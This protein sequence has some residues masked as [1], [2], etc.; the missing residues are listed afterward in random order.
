MKAK[1]LIRKVKGKG[2][3]RGA[4]IEAEKGKTF[5]CVACNRY[6]TIPPGQVGFCGVRANDNGKFN[7][8]VY[9]KPCAVWIDPIEKKPMFHFLPGSKSYSLGTFGCNFACSFCFTPDSTMVN[10]DFINDLDEVFDSCSKK[11]QKENGEI[12]FAGDRKTITASGNKET[13]SKVFRHHYSGPMLTIQPRHAPSL[14]CTPEHRF[15]VYKNGSIEKVP[16][17]ELKKNDLLI[18]PKINPKNEKV[19]LDCKAILEK[20]ISRIKKMRKLDQ[21]G[22]ERL[23]TLKKAGKTS[24]EI[25]TILKMHP[26]YIRHLNGKLKKEG[27]HD[28]TFTYDNLVFEKFDRVKFKM[29]KGDGVPR[30]IDVKEEFAEL[31]G[32]YCAEG[33]T[34]HCGQRPSSFNVVFSYGKHEKKLVDRTI[35]LL[36]KLFSVNPKTVRRRTTITVE[37]SKSSLGTLFKFLCG[38]K[39]KHKKVPSEIARSNEK[40]ISAFMK[41]FL[42]GDGCV[43]KEN[44]AFNTVSKKLAMGLYHLLLLLGYLPSFY[45]WEPPK[46]KIIEGRTV[47]QSTLYYVKISAEKF[48]E[49]FL[50]NTTFSPRKKSEENLRFKETKD[51]W[52]VPIFKIEKNDYDGYVYNCEVEGEHSYLANFIAVCNCQNF[53]ISQAPQEARFRDPKGWRGYFERLIE[54]SKISLPPELVVENALE[55]GC[56]S[57]SFTYNE[58]T[59]F[60]EYALDVID[61]AKEKGADLKFVYVTNGYETPE[62]WQAL[63]G[64][65]DAANID[66]KAYNQDFYGKLCKANLEP[67]RESIKLAKKAGIWVEVTTLIIP[68]ENDS[69]EELNAEAKFLASIDKDMP[70]HVTAFHPEYKML[71]KEPTGVEIL[72]KARE[73]GKAA[74]INHVYAGNIP[75]SNS[76]LEATYCSNPKCGKVAIERIGF[77]VT[78]NNMIDGKCRFCKEK[79]K[80]IWK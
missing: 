63:K 29:E 45:V 75:Y 4:G 19:I 34:S 8:M 3:E 2:T 7:L 22:L 36:K 71:D 33:H 38:G 72:I 32:Y 56:K 65:L 20:N 54:K 6:C 24:R 78:S 5:Q 37:V 1:P 30:F 77:S 57:I 40:V 49:W 67:V 42:A 41:A 48:R 51:M 68:G 39:A 17:F 12:G 74:G 13:I 11:I 62:C 14:T 80:G 64:K 53:D 61:A 46:T 55:A 50:G 35:E 26:S 43:L 59:I 76:N 9:G 23:L 52:L 28:N 58:P 66:L 27:I 25:G 73:I 69:L 79:I 44:I 18:I 70:W 21:A 16:A 47:N 15:F 60:T 31:L 10:D